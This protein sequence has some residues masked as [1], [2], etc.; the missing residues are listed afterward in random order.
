MERKRMIKD[1]LV[2][3]EYSDVFLEDLTGVPLERQVD[4][5]ID[6]VIGVVP[7]AKAPYRLALPKM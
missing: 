1:V 6:L 2:V 4:F 3:L 5:R 7:I